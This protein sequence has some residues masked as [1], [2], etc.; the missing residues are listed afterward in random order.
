MNENST[1]SLNGQAPPKSF[2]DEA[3]EKSLRASFDDW[4]NLHPNRQG[5]LREEAKKLQTD[6]LTRQAANRAA[7]MVKA[8]N[9]ADRDIKTITDLRAEG[10]PPTAFTLI[11]QFVTQ[12]SSNLLVAPTNTGGST[13]YLNMAEAALTGKPFLGVHK[14]HGGPYEVLWINPEEAEHQPRQRLDLMG[15]SD[16]DN[17]Y[18]HQ[19]WTRDNRFYLDYEHHIDR[20]LAALDELDILSPA[21]GRTRLLFIDGFGGT[22]TGRVMKKT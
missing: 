3:L 11:D 9:W 17:S 6:N 18:F 19:I 16:E 2:T 7:S 15:L 5:Q 20:M 14:V 12:E 8:P 21:L 10:D 1:P 13:L 22:S 4:D